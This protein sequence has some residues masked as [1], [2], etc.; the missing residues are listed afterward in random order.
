MEKIALILSD[1]WAVIDDFSKE[2]YLYEE[3]QNSFINYLSTVTHLESLKENID[4]FHS[5]GPRMSPYECD[6][7]I[8]HAFNKFNTSYKIIDSITEISTIYDHYLFCGFH[9]DSCVFEKILKLVSCGTATQDQIGIIANL[10][11]QRP[12]LFS[13]ELVFGNGE[14]AKEPYPYIKKILLDARWL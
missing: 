10:T 9:Y 7:H 12:E 1:T 14:T 3:E 4:V 11:L 2:F 13:C 5:I 8:H 6:K